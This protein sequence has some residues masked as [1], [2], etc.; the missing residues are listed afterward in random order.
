[1]NLELIG[2]PGVGKTTLIEKNKEEIQTHYVIVESKFS[3]IFQKFFAKYI[4]YVFYNRKL[5]DKKLARKLAYRHSFRKIKNASLDIFFYDSGLIQVI[6]EN[7]IETDFE[8]EA[9]KLNFL[10]A[11]PLSDRVLYLKDDLDNII[12]REMNR[13]PRRY[14]IN[15]KTIKERYMQLENLIQ[16]SVLHTMIDVRYVHVGKNEDFLKALQP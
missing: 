11:L 12:E 16:N 14:N 15:R 6:L 3:N 10:S 13:N 9:E 5:S 2:L 1:M 8:S 4:F 7:L